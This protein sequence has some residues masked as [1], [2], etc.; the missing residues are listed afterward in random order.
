MATVAELLLQESQAWAALSQLHGN[1]V[2]TATTVH[3]QDDVL[4]F[5]EELEVSLQRQQSYVLALTNL[6]GLADNLHLE[7]V[8]LRALRK[9]SFQVA[10]AAIASLTRSHR[11]RAVTLAEGLVRQATSE[12]A[13]LTAMLRGEQSR[14]RAQ[15]AQARALLEAITSSE[16]ELLPGN[17]TVVVGIEMPDGTRRLQP[18][19][20][21]LAA[22]NA[23]GGLSNLSDIL[24][25]ASTEN[26]APPGTAPTTFPRRSA[27]LT[28]KRTEDERNTGVSTSNA[29]DYDGGR[30]DGGAQGAARSGA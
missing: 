25:G 17:A 27:S 20:T 16:T 1:I 6:A 29:D 24:A 8:K 19:E 2:A 4:T 30:E 26:E 3:D 13:H 9:A 5:D 10:H 28:A 15:L 22:A 23:A 21:I 14:M 18:V 12:L 11:A 7:A